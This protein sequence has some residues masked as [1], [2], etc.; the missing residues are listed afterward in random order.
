[1]HISSE[2]Y[3][4]KCANAILCLRGSLSSLRA[5][6]SACA[7]RVQ[8]SVSGRKKVLGGWAKEGPGG[9]AKEGPGR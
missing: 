4:P 7:A 8:S 3:R 2:T 1:M 9:W 6:C 5:S